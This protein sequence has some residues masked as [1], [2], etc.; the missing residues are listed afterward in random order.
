MSTRSLLALRIRSSRAKSVLRKEQPREERHPQKEERQQGA[1]QET[2]NDAV[3][4]K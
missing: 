3:S 2:L 1:A 4:H